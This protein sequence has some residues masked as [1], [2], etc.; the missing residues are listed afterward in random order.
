MKK[1]C[2]CEDGFKRKIDLR[3]RGMSGFR[4]LD[5]GC[6]DGKHSLPFCINNTLIGLDAYSKPTIKHENFQFITGDV[7]NLPFKNEVFDVVISFD[8]IE[9][10]Q[11]DV[12]FLDEIYRVLKHE[13]L[14]LLGTP[15]RNR[16]SN[17]IRI[18]LGK[19]IEYP[20][21][22][23]TSKDTIPCVHIREYELRELQNLFKNGGFSQIKVMPFW[24]GLR[25]G[26]FDV[27]IVKPPKLLN[28]YVQYLFVEAKKC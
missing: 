23:G 12:L 26:K 27:G 20:L 7:T 1:V 13:G 6:G 21:N 10:I 9:H 3:A 19:K 22:L 16:F 24:F 15:N 4:I 25:I 14:V 2:S 5:A 18:L 17:K 8:V 28:K 11:N